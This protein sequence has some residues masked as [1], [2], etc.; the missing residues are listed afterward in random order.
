[1]YGAPPA[2]DECSQA[3]CRFLKLRNRRPIFRAAARE[4]LLF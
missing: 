3:S 4:A 2:A 1:M